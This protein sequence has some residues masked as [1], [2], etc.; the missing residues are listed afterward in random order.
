MKLLSYCC[1]VKGVH[2]YLALPPGSPIIKLQHGLKLAPR[3]LF[4]FS[5]DRR[6]FI[7]KRVLNLGGAY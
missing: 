4:N 6:A 2:L 3:L 1:T 5:A 7:G